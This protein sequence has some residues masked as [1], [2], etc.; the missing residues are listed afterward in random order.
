VQ[1]SA[2]HS[3]EQ[4]Q[5][6]IDAFIQVGRAKKVIP[7]SEVEKKKERGVGM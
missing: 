6:A 3:T 5:R 4:V 2:A 1:L 7:N